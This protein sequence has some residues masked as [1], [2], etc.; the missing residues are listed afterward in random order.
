MRA[1]SKKMEQREVTG[2]WLFAHAVCSVANLIGI[3]M[4]RW[5]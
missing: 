5:A 2:W 1:I 3:Q 4:I